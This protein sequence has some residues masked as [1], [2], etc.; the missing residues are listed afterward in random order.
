MQAPTLPKPQALRRHFRVS[1]QLPVEFHLESMG[2]RGHAPVVN[3]GLGGARLELPVEVDL[4][5][6]L[7]IT[8]PVEATGDDPIDLRARVIWTC[9]DPANA[10]YPTGVQFIGMEEKERQRLYTLIR[11]LGD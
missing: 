3:L 1:C 2:C 6:E 9:D 8:I 7:G 10:T 4:P 11:R 5:T